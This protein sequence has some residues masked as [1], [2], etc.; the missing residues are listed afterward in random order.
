M[1]M[2]CLNKVFT[3][4]RLPRFS[5]FAINKWTGI[6]ASGIVS[7]RQNDNLLYDYSYRV[8]GPKHCGNWRHYCAS[9]S[10]YMR[11]R[12]N[13]YFFFIFRLKI[14][15][16]W[17]NFNY[18]Y[19]KYAIFDCGNWSK[20]MHGCCFENNNELTNKPQMLLNLFFI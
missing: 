11:G 12:L 6:V 16:I 4:V 17:M 10:P 5:N 9:V 18:I 13:L 2:A 14:E 3:Y 20:I 1:T 15:E 7:I 19:F 8:N